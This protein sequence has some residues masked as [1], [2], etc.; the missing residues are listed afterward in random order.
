MSDFTFRSEGVDV[1]QIMRQIRA[2]IREK[3]GVDY[4]EQQIRELATAKLERFLDPEG[5]RSDLL[6]R[7]RQHRLTS[8]SKPPTYAFEDTT[9]FESDKPLVRFI[10]RLLKPI[11]KMFFNYNALNHVLH[12]QAAINH[13]WLQVQANRDEQELLAYE[14]MHNLV[15]ELTRLGIDV[16]N[17]RM[18]VESIASRLEFNERRA[19]ALEAVVQYRP[20]AQARPAQTETEPIGGVDPITGGESIR[21][22][23]RRRRRGRRGQGGAGVPSA[24]AQGTPG[25]GERTGSGDAAGAPSDAA[26]AASEPGPVAQPGD[27]QPA[28]QRNEPPSDA[29]EP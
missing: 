28:V 7:Y 1:E 21:T 16:K 24:A 27:S 8:A 10:R 23:R 6:E 2:R 11:L 25:T 20:D 22:R 13:H 12:T 9:L 29:S 14:V 15:V 4:T 18:R 5:V 3:R 26:P 17:M 19:R